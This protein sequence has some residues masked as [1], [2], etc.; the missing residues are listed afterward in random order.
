MFAV[1]TLPHKGDWFKHALVSSPKTDGGMSGKV[2]QKSP[3]N[4]KTAPPKIYCWCS[5][6]P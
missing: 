1:S 4:S 3:E 5:N 6:I 2:C